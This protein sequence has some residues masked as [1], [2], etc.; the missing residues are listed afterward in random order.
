MPASERQDHHVRRRRQRCGA[1]A[2]R[3]PAVDR[4]A[5]HHQRE[6]KPEGKGYLGD[7]FGNHIGRQSCGPPVPDDRCTRLV[8]HHTAMVR[9]HDPVSP[10]QPRTSSLGQSLWRLRSTG[11][12]TPGCRRPGDQRGHQEEGTGRPLRERRPRVGAE[13]G[14]GPGQDTRL[15]GQAGTGQGDPVRDPRRRHEHR[16]GQRRHRPRH[17]S[18]RPHLHPPLVAGPRQS[19][20][21]AGHPVADHRG[22]RRLQRL[23][24]P[25]RT[26]PRRPHWFRPTTHPRRIGPRRRSPGLLKHRAGALERRRGPRPTSAHRRVST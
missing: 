5:A 18:L 13:G 9:D 16:L 23:A 19:R 17:D 12:G 4:H 21:P 1:S 22:C 7:E 10:L 25:A 2:A 24:H 14:S 6:P 8:P 26:S 15:P 3:C 20:L 11:Q